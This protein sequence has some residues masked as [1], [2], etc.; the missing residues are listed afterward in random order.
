MIPPKWLL[1]VHVAVDGVVT[2]DDIGR[3]AVAVR[4]FDGDDGSAIVGDRG[5][6]AAFIGEDIKIDRLAVGSFAEGFFRG[7]T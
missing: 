4:H 3:L 6:R 5:F 7:G 2:E 1:S